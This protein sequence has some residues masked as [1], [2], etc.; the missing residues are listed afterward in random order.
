MA[1]KYDPTIN[2]GHILTFVG[3]VATGAGAYSL[4]E[5]RV[6]ILEEKAILSLQ[7]TQEQRVEQ[8]EANR[9]LRND[10]KDVQRTVNEM[11][12]SL[13]GRADRK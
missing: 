3:F 2:L 13:T 5:K 8:K 7:S 9:E 4:L 11:S 10:M 12:R 1:I 6:A